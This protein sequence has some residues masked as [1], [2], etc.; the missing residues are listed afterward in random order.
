MT[1]CETIRL[2]WILQSKVVVQV[3]ALV[4]RC[5]WR[6]M[7]RWIQRTV[8]LRCDPFF[9]WSVP[10]CSLLNVAAVVPA[11]SV[12]SHSG[13][14]FLLKCVFCRHYLWLWGYRCYVMWKGFLGPRGRHRI[15][16]FLILDIK[17]DLFIRA[18]I[19]FP[20]V[21]FSVRL[22]QAASPVTL[23]ISYFS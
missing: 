2:F 10:G 20:N 23:Y 13:N 11:I 15:F 6:E 1:K 9:L 19:F 14:W 12:V 18:K 16:V 22:F 5:W 7:L 21:G 8:L 3:H 17:V 4:R